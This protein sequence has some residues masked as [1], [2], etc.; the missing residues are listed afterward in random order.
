MKYK[1]VIFDLDGTL[2]NTLDDLAD[3]VNYVLAS[4]G[5]PLR[6]YEEIRLFVG[7]GIYKLVE[8]ALPE[9][10]DAEITDRCYK[11]FIDFYKLNMMK[12]TRPYEGIEDIIKKLKSRG[13][14]LAVVTNKADFAAKE[15]CKSIFGGCFDLVIGST[16]ERKNKPS[17]ESVE[18]ILDCLKLKKSEVIYVGD[19][20]VD[21]MTAENAGVDFVAVLWGFRKSDDFRGYKLKAYA[22]D[23]NEL[24]NAVLTA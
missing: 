10:T 22:K 20:E 17:A 12:K 14:L 11:E 15:L 3:S 1:A 7:N 5:Y 23:V 9:N 4:H 18:Y 19:S 8:R 13:M 24:E 21:A 2:L 16:P 6:T